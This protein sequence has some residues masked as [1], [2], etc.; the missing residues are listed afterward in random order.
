MGLLLAYNVSTKK[1]R[2]I[3]KITLEIVVFELSNT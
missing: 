2:D 1:K 3:F